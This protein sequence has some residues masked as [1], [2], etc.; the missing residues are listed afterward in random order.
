MIDQG[1]DTDLREVL[2]ICAIKSSCSA[3]VIIS[4]AS[5]TVFG[6]GSMFQIHALELCASVSTQP[7]HNVQEAYQGYR[8]SM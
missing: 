7:L 6:V 8:P 1:K 4:I 5:S 3:F 2:D